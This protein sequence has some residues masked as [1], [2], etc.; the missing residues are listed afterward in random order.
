[1]PRSKIVSDRRQ[2]H[3]CLCQLNFA[4]QIAYR[5]DVY[6]YTYIFHKRQ[7]KLIEVVNLLEL[8]L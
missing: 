2:L 4:A 3:S 6:T 7:S 1:M 5:N 8:A